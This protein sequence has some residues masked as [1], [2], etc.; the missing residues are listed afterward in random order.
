MQMQNMPMPNVLP[1]SMPTEM[2]MPTGMSMPTEMSMST[3]MSMPTGMYNVMS[4][5]IP[6]SM[7]TGMPNAMSTG[8]PNAMSAGMPNAMPMP[9]EMYNTMSMPTGMPNAM[10]TQMSMQDN[11]N[12]TK[13]SLKPLEKPNTQKSYDTKENFTVNL[14]KTANL[15]LYNNL[16]NASDPKTLDLYLNDNYLMEAN[17]NNYLS[18]YI[19]KNDSIIN[20][21]LSD[22]INKARDEYNENYELNLEIEK[23]IS[24]LYL[25][26]NAK[27]DKIINNL[28]KMR[29]TD[30]AN[31]YF[32]LKKLT[33]INK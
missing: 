25:D 19:K 9:T 8:M 6:N 3:G 24:N 32:F 10:P 12:T 13:R 28:D 18:V 7:S 29:I 2:S 14:D 5:G 11:P 30:M 15:A 1:M 17:N 20:K 31:D 26:L 16:F 27:N 23:E 22:S 21:Q 4:T 33:K